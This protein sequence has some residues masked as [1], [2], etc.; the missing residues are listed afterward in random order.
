M[1]Y[2]V[3]YASIEP[4]VKSDH[5]IISVEFNVDNKSTRGRGFW[6][7]NSSL[8]MDKDYVAL[9]KDVIKDSVRNI[10]I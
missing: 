3:S 7:F 6:K 10:H 8:L 2:D 9:V 5:S 4:S 1:L